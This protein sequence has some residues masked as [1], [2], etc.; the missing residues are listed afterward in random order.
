M[1]I[2]KTSAFHCWLLLAVK[3]MLVLLGLCCVLAACN[4]AD[5]NLITSSVTL[6]REP[7]VLT[8]RG[9]LSTPSQF[10][11]LCIAIPTEYHIEA[12]TLRN[13]SG[14]EVQLRATLVTT[15]GLRNSF[16]PHGFLQGRYVCLQSD[17]SQKPGIRYRQVLITSSAPFQ[18]NDIRWIC[19]D[20]L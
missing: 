5:Q 14:T 11:L 4:N 8:P 7:I 10:N 19:T 17:S 9:P 12:S 18:T 6:D 1:I 3:R 15:E 13:A 20:K 2:P 16:S